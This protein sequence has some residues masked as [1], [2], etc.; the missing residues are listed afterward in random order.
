MENCLIF[1]MSNINVTLIESCENFDAIIFYFLRESFEWVSRI[2]NTLL[3]YTAASLLWLRFMRLSEACWVNS[4]MGGVCSWKRE[5]YYA[6]E[7]PNRRGVSGRYFKSR[8]SKWMASS[9][10]PPVVDCR[11][12]GSTYP[13]LMELCI[14][15]IRE[16]LLC[17]IYEL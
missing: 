10:F 9:F 13:S 17:L 12:R 11:P 1:V 14:H 4:L 15:K 6:D 7:N 2:C 16:V 8:S 3:G 5:Y